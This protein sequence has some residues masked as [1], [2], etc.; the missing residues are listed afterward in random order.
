MEQTIKWVK[1]DRPEKE[2]NYLVWGMQ[3]QN[4]GLFERECYVAFYDGREEGLSPFGMKV[5]YHAEIIGPNG[6][7]YE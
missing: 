1:G 7:R 5:E 3:E 4:D 2:G 6:E